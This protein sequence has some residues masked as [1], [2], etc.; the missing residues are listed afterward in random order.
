[1]LSFLFLEIR[2][3]TFYYSNQIFLFFN[4][5]HDHFFSAFFFI[6]IILYLL[7]INT[8]NQ[9]INKQTNKETDKATVVPLAGILGLQQANAPQWSVAQPQ[10]LSQYLRGIWGNCRGT[11]WDLGC[12]WKPNH[13]HNVLYV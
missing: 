8:S 2:I 7:F 5:V 1:M 13:Q 12:K 11:T 9:V 3:L 6:N 10:S 4:I